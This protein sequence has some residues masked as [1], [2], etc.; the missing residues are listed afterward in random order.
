MK[1][2]IIIFTFLLFT[3]QLLAQ[4]EKPFSP[5]QFSFAYP[6]STNGKD[7]N[8]YTNGASV[9]LLVGVSNNENS[10][11]LAGI[12]NIISKKATGVQLAG[13]SNHIGNV[14]KGLAIAGM[15]NI[16]S[17]SYKGVQ[18]SGVWNNSGNETIGMMVG[19]IGN[20]VKGS[21]D[22]LQIASFINIAKDIRGMQF[23]GFINKA[24]KV[25]G[26]QFAALINIAEESNF[27]IGLINIIKN[28][29]KG[30][31]L[32]YDLLG[33]TVIS[34]RSGGKYTYGILGIGY[35]PKIKDGDK[36]VAEA[37][38]GINVPINRWLQINNE[39]KVTSIGCMADNTSST[40]NI[41]YLLAPSFKLWKH[42]NFFGGASINYF[43]S[44]SVGSENLLPNNYIW[45][46]KKNKDLQRVYAGY[47]IGVQYIF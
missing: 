10:F 25:K 11:V 41:G 39:I 35:N 12:S 15:T 29:E 33:N 34:F 2:N 21:F 16:T 40:N 17:A 26:V 1:R 20:M 4:E 31:A 24:K 9:N 43:I 36:M 7:A 23:A 14:G 6:L 45:N 44:D 8:E 28:G 27:P 13:F 30:I 38:Y 3:L 22:G 42:Y 19:G 32:T 18:I 37:G 46:K 47:Q 5:F